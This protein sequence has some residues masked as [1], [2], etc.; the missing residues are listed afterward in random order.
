M[1]DKLYRSRDNKVISGV[2]S[3]LGNYFGV[4]PLIFRMGFV[5]LLL[6]G[7]SSIIIYLLLL[8]IIPKEP[9]TTTPNLN[10]SDPSSGGFE[11]FQQEDLPADETMNSTKTIFGLLFISGGALMLLNNLV[12]SINLKKLW[13]AVL[14]II[15]LGL[16]MQKN[17]KEDNQNNP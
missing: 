7:G 5:A 16:L 13:P 9:I 17:K 15:G 3:G 4:D 6:A 11:Q 2:C 10:T 8:I 12:P 1:N 14:I